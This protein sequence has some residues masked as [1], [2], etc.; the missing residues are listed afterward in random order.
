VILD[1][2]RCQVGIESTIVLATDH[3]GYQ[4]LRHGLVDEAEINAVLPGML[5]SDLNSPRVS[6][7]LASHYQPDKP[8]YCFSSP[9]AIQAFCREASRSIYILSFNK[10]Q[11]ES[12]TLDYQLPRSPDQVAFELYYQ[13][14]IADQSVADCIVVEL[15]PDEPCWEGVRERLFK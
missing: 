4:I 9:E 6:G 15:P 5:R 2:G 3:Q 13:L 8:L 7:Q 14:R 12:A 11:A 1:G 10:I